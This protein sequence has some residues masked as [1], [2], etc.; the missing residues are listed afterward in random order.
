MVGYSGQYHAASSLIIRDLRDGNLEW[1]RVTDPTAGHVDDLIIGGRGRVDAY[2]VKWSQYA[3][4]ISFND[5]V[6]SPNGG[7]CLIAQLAD[8][9][10]RLRRRFLNDRVVVHLL[11]N[12]AASSSA[13][14]PT[15]E[16]A[17]VPAHFSAFMAQAWQP[18]RVNLS[19]K[20]EPKVSDGWQVAWKELERA[21]GLSGKFFWTL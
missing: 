16:L 21:S 19:K 15:G 2:Q 4:V 5:L 20:L 18:A 1:I 9:W 12:N 3:G 17:P 11:T 14:V 13:K 8:G 6:T 7:L 10:Q